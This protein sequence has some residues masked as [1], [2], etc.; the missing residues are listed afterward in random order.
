[1]TYKIRVATCYNHLHS[2]QLWRKC[3][4][5]YGSGCDKSKT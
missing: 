1:L 2:S 3:E 4:D 5:T